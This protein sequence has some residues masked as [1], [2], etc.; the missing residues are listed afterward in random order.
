VWEIGGEV[1]KSSKKGNN[2][3]KP[4]PIK[5]RETK[6]EKAFLAALS[7]TANVSKSCEIARIDRSTA[8]DHRNSSE[9]FRQDWDNALEVACD[10]LELEA[11][12]RAEE[13]CKKTIF[14][15]GEPIGEEIN[16]SDTLMIFLL[17]AHRPEKYRETVR[18]EHSGPNGGPI[19]YVK[20]EDLTDD[21]LA[22]RIQSG[23]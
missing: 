22:E 4:T 12:R 6:W 13:G 19:R 2:P 17:K 1:K 7:E 8:Y 11:R 21:E 18:N 10:G 16:Y 3:Q 14:Y 15:Q 5:R 20:A 23:Q 9:A